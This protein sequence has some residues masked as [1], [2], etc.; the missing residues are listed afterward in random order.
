MSRCGRWMTNSDGSVPSGPPTTSGL[1][2]K[3]VK[4]L[5]H[6]IV[7]ELEFNYDR[8]EVIAD[9]GLM[10]VVYIAEPGSRSAESLTLSRAGQRRRA[11]ASL[12]ATPIVTEPAQTRISGIDRPPL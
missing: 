9:P 3:G 5:N 1:H 8:L 11:T 4:Q 10:L 2:T 7:G 6:P 12:P